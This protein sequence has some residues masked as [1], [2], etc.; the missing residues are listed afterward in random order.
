MRQTED[1]LNRAVLTVVGALLAGLSHAAEPVAAAAPPPPAKWETTAYA[2]LTLTRGNRDTFLGTL[3]L[4]TRRKWPKDELALGISGAYGEVDSVEN[5]KTVTAYGQYNRLATERFYYGA[6]AD[7]LYDGI[8]GVDYRVKLSPLAGYYLLKTPKTTLALEAGP[9][10]VI[11]KQRGMSQNTYL[12]MR[13]G[14]RFEHKF[15]E[16][17]RLWQTLE[18]LPQ[19]DSWGRNYLLISEVGVDA[20]ITK[21]VGLRTV[22]QDTYDSEPSPGRKKH[23]VRLI[24]GVTYKF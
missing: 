18:Y 5:Q 10:A 7:A 8:A 19:V 23:D 9:S 13:F 17:T 16:T 14:E 1:N 2:G 11:E 24:A 21:R 12:G 15:S 3:S 22:L 4:D 20:A 6:R